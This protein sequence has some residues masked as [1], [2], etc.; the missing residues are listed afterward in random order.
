MQ[1]EKFFENYPAWIVALSNLNSVL[2]YLCGAL[3]IYKIGLI[4]LVLYLLFILLLEYRLISK[5]CIDCYY[6]GKTCAFGKGKLSALLCKKGDSK[7]FVK[8]SVTWKDIL[9]DFMV[10]LIPIII[11]ICLLVV[12]FDLSTLFLIVVLLILT[13]AGNAFGRGNLACKHCKQ[14]KQG[15]PALKLFEKK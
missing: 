5:H 8:T 3:I 12:A 1:K 7:K 9:I 6:Y 2:I 13:F 11:G 10:S 15:C 4:W 14:R